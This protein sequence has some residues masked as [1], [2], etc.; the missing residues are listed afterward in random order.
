MTF[1]TMIVLD[2]DG[3]TNR[4]SEMDTEILFA[5]VVFAVI[6][7]GVFVFWKKRKK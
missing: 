4:R 7:A 3:R 5:L 6:S 1:Q 2:N